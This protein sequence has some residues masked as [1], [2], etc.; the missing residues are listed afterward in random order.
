MKKKFVLDGIFRA[1]VIITGTGLLGMAIAWFLL[2][3]WQHQVPRAMLIAAIALGMFGVWLG[4]YSERG[5]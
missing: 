1:L 3:E 5:K 2:P 4:V